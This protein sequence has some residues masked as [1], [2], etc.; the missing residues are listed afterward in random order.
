[1]KA[2][3]L[4]TLEKLEL[5]AIQEIHIFFILLLN[6]TNS[7]ATFPRHSLVGTLM[8]STCATEKFP[9]LEE[10]QVVKEAENGL[11]LVK[12]RPY[13]THP[14]LYHYREKTAKN[15]H[16]Y[17]YLVESG[18]GNRIA[19]FH[20]NDYWEGYLSSENSEDKYRYQL[21]DELNRHMSGMNEYGLIAVDQFIKKF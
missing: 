18:H 10:Y 1:M 3:I 6:L 8:Y 15:G 9:Y 11:Y 14:F 7:K 12:I 5:A 20:P 19:F 2:S 16:V 4:K 17:R 21:L 13:E